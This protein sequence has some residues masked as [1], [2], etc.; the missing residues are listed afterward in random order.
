MRHGRCGRSGGPEQ[1]D[2]QA[3]LLAS[4][5]QAHDAGE[6]LLRA[7]QEPVN[8]S[9]VERITSLVN[10]RDEALQTAGALSQPGDH[11]DLRPVLQ[12]LVDQQRVLEAELVRVK[13]GAEQNVHDVQ[14]KRAVLDGTRKLIN[15]GRRGRLVNE[16]R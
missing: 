4:Y 14:Q 13:G 2:R 15:P 1:V 12:S 11:Q 6:E 9:L 16:V 8:A 5:Q 10:R 3:E 7:L